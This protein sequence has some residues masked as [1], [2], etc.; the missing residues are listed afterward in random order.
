MTQ[1]IRDRCLKNP[2]I[3]PCVASIGNF[4]GVHL[5]HQKLINQLKECAKSR[6]LPSMIITFFP[7]PRSFFTRAK[8]NK[9]G[10]MTFKEKFLMLQS[11]GIDFVCVL[12][13]NEKL[14]SLSAEDFVKDILI[15]DLQ[16]KHLVVGEDF[17]F[18]K[19]REGDVGFLQKTGSYYGLTLGM[20][21]LLQKEGEKV[22]SSRIRQ[23][24]DKGNQIEAERLLG[25]KIEV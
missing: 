6:D 5:G 12:R 16:V 10:I 21:S 19:A 11:L 3:S 23:V 7:S 25:R 17:R 13:F 14:A 8:K 20:V 15:K 18:G 4:D 22:S 24:L 2:I 9:M 1:L